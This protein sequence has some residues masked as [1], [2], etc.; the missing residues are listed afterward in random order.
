M[1][2]ASSENIGLCPMSFT[3]SSNQMI[4][5]RLQYQR[6]TGRFCDVEL[7]VSTRSFAAHRNILAAHSPYFDA[8]LKSCKVTKEQITIVSKY[9]QVFELCLNYM[10]SG[11][12]VIDRASV[13][14]LLRFANDLMMVKLKN[15]CAEYLD[16]YLDAANCLSIRSLAQ[17]Y[18]LP[19]LI[20][21]ATDYFDSNLNRCLLESRDIIAYTYTQLTRLIGDPKYS[22]C[23]TADTYLKLIVRWVGED[24]GKREEIFRLL[25]ESCEFREVS[26]DTL[27]FL[28]DYSPLLSKSQKSRFLLLHTIDESIPWIDE[29]EI[30]GV[31]ATC[32]L[33]GCHTYGPVDNLDPDDC[34]DE[35]DQ[36]D[37]DGPSMCLFCGLRTANEEVGD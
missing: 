25:L 17:R 26:A 14:E 3:D 7:V 22:D 13:S 32:S 6:S 18:N 20:K 5:E 33:E 12:V 1:L 28:L 23:I 21:S 11:S 19:G 31:Y 30:D 15:Y 36:P 16:R 9:P 35:E 2:V 4:F 8:I 10:Y 24:I 29:D 37:E 34:E 27:E